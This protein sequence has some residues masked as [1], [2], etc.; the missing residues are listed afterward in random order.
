M[1]DNDSKGLDLMVTGIDKDVL[2]AL[3]AVARVLGKT[4]NDVI[5]ELIN[6]E[7]V[8]PVTIYAKNSLL[9]KAMDKDIS[10]RFGCT[11][12]S[13][14]LRNEHAIISDR[15]YKDILKLETINDVD[16]LFKRNIALIDFRAN[17]V[18]SR[19]AYTQLPEG[20]SL[21]FALF[22]EVARSS[23]EV[24]DCIWEMI[25]QP[26]DIEGYFHDDLKALK[27]KLLQGSD[28]SSLKS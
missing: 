6:N 25:F 7:F 1:K 21:I 13:N 4:K 5:L 8:N 22:V 14:D 26:T 28:M 10:E 11:L 19:K 23:Q 9:V 20:I 27:V 15:F 2:Y 24:I 18:C 12:T 16:L 3:N 17:Q